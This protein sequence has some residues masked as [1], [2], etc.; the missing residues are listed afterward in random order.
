MECLKHLTDADLVKLY[1]DGN[2]DAFDL[3]LSRHSDK[4]FSYILFFV[5]DEAEAND[6]FQDTFVKAVVTIQ[7]GGY[8][9]KSKFYSWIARIAHNLIV[10]LFRQKRIENRVQEDA[11]GNELTKDLKYTEPAVDIL[12]DQTQV[13]QD[14]K[15]MVNMLP[16]NQKEVVYMRYYQNLS[17]KEIADI[18]GVS[19]NTALGR[20]RY[21]ILSLRKMAYRNRLCMGA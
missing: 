14:V 6:V 7:R 13:A 19:I 17:F 8:S 11:V 16:A 12:M 21:A 3:L 18:T 15:V 20:M 9:E 5:K 2:N 4:L 1:Q 10:D